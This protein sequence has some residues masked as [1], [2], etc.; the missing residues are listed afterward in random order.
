[1]HVF[2][3]VRLQN[4]VQGIRFAPADDATLEKNIGD[5][6]TS[7]NL[8]IPVNPAALQILKQ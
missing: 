1:V 2:V 6:L 5:L 7:N 8:N 4:L 3:P